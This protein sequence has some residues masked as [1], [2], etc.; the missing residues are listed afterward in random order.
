MVK[1]VNW[2]QF[3]QHVIASLPEEVKRRKSL[4]VA[5]LAALPKSYERRDE[6]TTMLHLLHAHEAAQMKFQAL[7]KQEVA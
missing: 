4:L 3:A 1:G 5:L 6:I 2:D 7:F